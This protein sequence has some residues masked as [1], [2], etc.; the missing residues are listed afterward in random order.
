MAAGAI[1][2]EEA[3][4]SCP[5]QETKSTAI[6]WVAREMTKQEKEAYIRAALGARNPGTFILWT[7]TLGRY[8]AENQGDGSRSSHGGPR[9]D[10]LRPSSVG[11]ARM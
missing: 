10:L 5:F 3:A 7:S 1:Q 4:V 11:R 8:W 2:A 9:Q 6:R